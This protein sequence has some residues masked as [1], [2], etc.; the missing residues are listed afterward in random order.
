MK[1]AAQNLMEKLGCSRQEALEIIAED[2]EIDK[3]SMKE[4]TADLTKEQRKAIKAN[5]KAGFKKRTPVKRERKIDPDKL[6]LIQVLDDALCNIADNV[7]ERT[8][9]TEIHF[10]YNDNSYTVRLIKHRPPKKQGVFSA[11]AS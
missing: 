4:V 3:M 6:E 1:D 8:N 7:Q 5:S 9:E 11:L 10:E 2:S